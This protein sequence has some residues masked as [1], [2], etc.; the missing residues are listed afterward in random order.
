MGGA[1]ALSLL[2][3]LNGTVQ[4]VVSD[5]AMPGVDGLALAERMA[6]KWPATPL[7]LV[8]GQGGP[9]TG[10][11]GRFLPKPYTA[12]ALLDTMPDLVSIRQH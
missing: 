6:A 11:P 9:P 10:Y 2:A 8:S 3:T 12:D 5:I 1:E 7:L 4:L